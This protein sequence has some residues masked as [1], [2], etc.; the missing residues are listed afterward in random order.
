[1]ANVS[2]YYVGDKNNLISAKESY[3]VGKKYRFTVLSP[4]LIRLEY[5]PLGVFEDRSTSMVINRKFP[6]VYYSITES[7]TLI[8]IDTGIFTLTYVKDSELKSSALGSNIKAMINGTKI[9]W[10]MN[11]PEVKNLRSINYSIDSIKDKIILDNGLYSLDGF[12][13][14]DDSRSLVLD[15]NNNFIEREKNV[16]DIYLFMYNKDFEGCLTDYFTLTGYPSLIPRYALGAWWYKN[17]NYKENDIVNLIDKFNSENI[18]ISIFLL[19]DYWHDNMNNYTPSIDLREISNY[20]SD[21]NIKFGVTINPKLEIK[22]GSN[23]YNAIS[24]YINTDKFNFIPLSN[25]K[26]GL[27]LNFFVNNL[28]SLGVNIF[29]IDYNNS[30]DKIN[31]WK[32]NHYHYGLNEIGNLR[33][34][35]LSRNPGIASHRY[36]IMWSGKT[37]VNWNTLNLLPRYNLQGYNIGVSFIA[38]P[39]GGYYGGIE[40]DELYLRYIQFACFS[41]IFLLASEGGKYYKR[42]PWRWNSIIKNHISFYMNLRYKLIPYLYSESYNYHKTGHGLIKPFYYDYPRIIDEPMYKNQ[43]FLG[44]NF[45]VAPIT[46]KKNNVINRVMKKV[47]VPNGIWFD[48]LQGKKYNGNKIYNNFYRD[49]DYPVFV[50]AGSIIPMSVNVKENIPITLELNIYPLDSSE[51]E[52]YED[53]GISKNYLRGLYMI[54]KFSYQYEVDNYTFNIKRI[55]GKNLLSRRSYILRFKN[56]KNITEI[57]INDEMVKYNCYYDKDD[58]I[59]EIDNFIVGRDLEINIKGKDIFVSSVTYINE[60]IK[61][62]LYDLQLE[63]ELKEKI[64]EVLFSDLEI[65]KKRIKLK[66]LK[67][68][69]LDSKYIKIF[70]NLLEY[71]EKI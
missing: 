64:D 36:P 12:C 50:K 58:F 67:R 21:F 27:Y 61:D 38:H 56:T 66:K 17:D 59:I 48:F 8:Q 39:I 62:I 6:K 65:R 35:I 7:D 40:E 41:S 14:L 18:P 15:E 25:D 9:E 44:R 10:Q 24:N 1:M 5:N 60:E 68:K 63:T 52:L 4:R 34:L 47:Y 70:I 28:K 13:V 23:E 43:Y 51:Y 19:G 22:K 26:I 45:F 42:E 57:N 16:K 54:T 31:L 71:I 55:D 3:I 32:L 33:G 29:S 46:N 20:L 30:L 2:N 49:E 69:G 53:D 11:N 37:K